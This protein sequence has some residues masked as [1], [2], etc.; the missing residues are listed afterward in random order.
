MKTIP[1]LKMN[2]IGQVEGDY[3]KLLEQLRAEFKRQHP[4]EDPGKYELST[5]S[6]TF[7]KPP[8]E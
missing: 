1:K 5:V 6:F 2:E 7:K 3:T 8:S 4:K